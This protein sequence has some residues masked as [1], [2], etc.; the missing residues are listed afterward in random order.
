M[1]VF[2]GW[3]LLQCVFKLL[4]DE[5]TLLQLSH[6]ARPIYIISEDEVSEYD[7]ILEDLVGEETYAQGVDIWIQ[8]NN[9]LISSEDYFLPFV[10]PPKDEHPLSGQSHDQQNLG[11]PPE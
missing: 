7:I 8:T 6:A 10:Q 5:Q 2:F 11:E 4:F 3:T 1:F 9:G